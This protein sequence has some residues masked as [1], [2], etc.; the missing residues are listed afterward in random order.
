MGATL[1]VLSRFF[2]RS[3]AQFGRRVGDLYATNTLGAVIGCAM[4]GFFLIPVYG[5]RATVYVAAGVNMLIA[6]VILIVDRLRDHEPV[7]AEAEAEAR[8]QDAASAAAQSSTYL[9]WVLLGSFALSGFA[10][11]V[12]EN[13]WTRSLTLVIGSSIYSF[14]DHAGDVSHRPGVGRIYLCASAGQSRSALE[15]LRFDRA[16]GR[17]VGAGDDPAVRKPAADLCPLAARLRRYLHGFSLLAD[18]SVGAGDVHSDDSTW[19]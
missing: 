16:M 6:I 3:F 19:A 1:P 14:T 8:S 7:A 17:L 2:V 10:S 13:A 4:G 5:M 18:F 12:Y 9:D 11:L 15:H